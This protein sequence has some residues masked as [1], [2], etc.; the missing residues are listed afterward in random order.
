MDGR[1]LQAV[2]EIVG[3]GCPVYAVLDQHCNVSE[4]MVTPATAILVER[5]YP[6]TDM[7]LRA[8][9]AV[10]LMMRELRGEVRPVMA[11]RSIPLLWNAPRMITAHQP[12]LRQR[13]RERARR[14]RAGG[15][16]RECAH[17]LNLPLQ[18]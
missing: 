3:E 14:G 4:A 8:R 11:W 9:D 5:T 13:G 10:V 17:G 12:A 18:Y 2:R 6:H 1:I 16:G 15:E 7:A